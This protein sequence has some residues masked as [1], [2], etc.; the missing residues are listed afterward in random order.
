VTIEHTD[1]DFLDAQ[2]G[3]GARRLTIERARLLTNF[4]EEQRMFV[5]SIEAFNLL[6]GDYIQ[7]DLAFSMLGLGYDEHAATTP[8]AMNEIARL[9]FDRVEQL[10]RQ[11][12]FDVWLVPNDEFEPIKR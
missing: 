3:G 4:A 8:K 12:I 7:P 10:Q 5:R 11:M 9:V 1:Q 6:E 2:T